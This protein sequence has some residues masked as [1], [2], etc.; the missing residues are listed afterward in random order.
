MA[1]CTRSFTNQSLYHHPRLFWASQYLGLKAFIKTIYG[2]F[3][4]GGLIAIITAGILAISYKLLP[5]SKKDDLGDKLSNLYYY[6]LHQLD[7][8]LDDIDIKPNYSEGG[9]P[10]LNYIAYTMYE[11]FALSSSPNDH[12]HINLPVESIVSALAYLLYDLK[13]DLSLNI[14]RYCVP[15]QLGLSALQCYK[16]NLL[17]VL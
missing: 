14:A 4:K 9:N 12:L 7:G 16:I 11:K 8:L 3:V 13:Q 10:Q 6:S 5:T 1:N 15:T 17:V 2:S